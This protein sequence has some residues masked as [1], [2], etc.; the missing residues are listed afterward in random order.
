MKTIVISILSQILASTSFAQTTV[1][2][3]PN[4]V[5]GATAVILNLDNES[6]IDKV[7]LAKAQKLLDDGRH[8]NQ[9]KHSTKTTTP[10]GDVIIF[11]DYLS[12]RDATDSIEKLAPIILKRNQLIGRVGG[13]LYASNSCSMK[14]LVRLNLNAYL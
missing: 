12:D 7:T 3:S 6:G 13:A 2:S 14:T 9:L 8:R 1:T 11:L 4:R 5:L 10:K